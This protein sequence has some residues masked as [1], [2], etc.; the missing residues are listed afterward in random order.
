MAQSVWQRRFVRGFAEGGM[1]LALVRTGK[2]LGDAVLACLDDPDFRAE[3]DRISAERLAAAGH[4]LV[5][6][7]LRRL[8]GADEGT[9]KAALAIW[10]Q[11]TDEKRRPAART[12]ST[13]PAARRQRHTIP[14]ERAA[15]AQ[16]AVRQAEDFRQLLEVI[17]KR[18]AAAEQKSAGA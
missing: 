8:E 1:D 9:E 7:L 5:D 14:A 2:T 16:K 10:Q 13:R 18:L 4:K 12:E 6:L 3:L 11:L 15:A 17:R